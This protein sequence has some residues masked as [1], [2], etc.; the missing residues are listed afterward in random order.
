MTISRKLL[1]RS[2][3]VLDKKQDVRLLCMQYTS[4]LNPLMLG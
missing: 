3:Y 4:C 1:A 2:S